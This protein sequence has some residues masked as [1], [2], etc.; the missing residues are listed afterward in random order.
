MLIALALLTLTA[1]LVILV[2]LGFL[3]V[4]I[5]REDRSPEL[6]CRPPT[7]V[8]ALMRHLC[9]LHVR[10]PPTRGPADRA[11][12]DGRLASHGIGRSSGEAA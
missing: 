8:A 1:T 4:S 10:R 5:R 11:R 6:A 2:L 9:G 3:L 12:P 7:R